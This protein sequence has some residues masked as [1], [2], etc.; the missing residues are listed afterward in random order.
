[1]LAFEIEVIWLLII[2]STVAV[3][4]RWVRV[5]YTIAL[6]ITGIAVGFFDVLPDL[7]LTPEL[8]FHVFLP[9]LLF[10]AAFHLQYHDLR[11]N[12]GPI[13]VLAVPG[14]LIAAVVTGLGIYLY[15]SAAQIRELTLPVALLFGSM[16]S[17]T[18]PISVIA[19]FREMGVS[20]RLTSIVEG[21]SL[22]NDGAAVV[23]FSILLEMIRGGEVGLQTGLWKFFIVVA[24]GAAVGLALGLIF[25]RLTAMIDDHLIE[26]TLTTILAFSAYLGAEHFHFSGVISVVLAGLMVGNYGTRIGMSPTTLVSVGDF[27]EYAAFVVNSVIFL[28]I[29]LEVKA[30]HFAEFFGVLTAAIAVTLLG[31]AVGVGVSTAVANR[32]FEPVAARWK[33]ALVWGGLRGSLSMALALSLPSDFPGRQLILTLVFGVVAFSLIFQG[34]TMKPLLRRWGM[35]G[36]RPERLAFETERGKLLAK[37]K[38][39]EELGGLERRGIITHETALRLRPHLEGEIETLRDAVS[40][41]FHAEDVIRDEEAE[42]ARNRL[43]DAERQAVK[44]AFRDGVISE[45]SMKEIIAGIHEEKTASGGSPGH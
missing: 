45:E 21:E 27:W 31:R 8:V 10:E 28:L 16:I 12:A 5:P 3:A 37:R 14:M 13:L 24:G 7:H 6:V 43:R 18:D 29:G 22:F 11:D 44:E 9:I 26:I 33:S 15:A 39:L 34:L 30:G 38:A 17:A 32:F 36:S 1:M 4:V 40:R 20:R 2:A 25:S 23:I 19:L 41:H 35:T 42:V